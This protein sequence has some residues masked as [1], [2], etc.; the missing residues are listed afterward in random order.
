M[1]M[2]LVYGIKLT[3]VETEKIYPR[4][5][6]E[7]EIEKSIKQTGWVTIF[8]VNREFLDNYCFPIAN[9]IGNPF[10]L[11][12]NYEI[13]F[14][15]IIGEECREVTFE[16]EGCCPIPTSPTHSVARHFDEFIDLNPVLS[17]IKPGW[18]VIGSP[19]KSKSVLERVLENCR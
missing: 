17:H 7:S 14:Y 1:T 9:A 19:S 4:N 12:G 3:N 13:E 16:T 8:N 6:D 11:C 5:Y 18:F 2:Q 10:P 15:W